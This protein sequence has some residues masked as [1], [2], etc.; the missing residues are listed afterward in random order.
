MAEKEWD[1]F[2]V[3]KKEEMDAVLDKNPILGRCFHTIQN[4]IQLERISRNKKPNN[5]YIVCNQDEPYAEEV[6]KIILDGEKKKE[7]N[8]NV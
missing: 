2:Y 5:R 6:W 3:F 8:T 7:L 1:K 4:L